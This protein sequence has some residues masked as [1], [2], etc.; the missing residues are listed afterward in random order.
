LGQ[1]GTR[2]R[3][4]RG[5]SAARSRHVEPRFF[6]AG[7]RLRHRPARK[8]GDSTYRRGLARESPGQESGSLGRRCWRGLLRAGGWPRVGQIGPGRRASV[9]GG[10]P[11]AAGTRQASPVTGQVLPAEAKSGAGGWPRVGVTWAD[12]RQWVD[13]LLPLRVVGGAASR[14]RVGPDGSSWCC[15]TGR[16]REHP[17]RV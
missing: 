12:R 3:L 10:P 13:R 14:R 9:G 6:R 8:N 1:A 16:M 4:R 11:H 15:P 17:P 2:P 5:G 7:Q